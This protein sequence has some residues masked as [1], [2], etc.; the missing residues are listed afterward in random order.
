MVVK[1][2]ET[3]LDEA[4]GHLSVGRPHK[5]REAIVP[6]FTDFRHA[7]RDGSLPARIDERQRRASPGPVLCFHP[8]LRRGPRSRAEGR[9][10]QGVEQ[11]AAT[12]NHEMTVRGVEG[13]ED[14]CIWIEDKKETEQR[15]EPAK[16]I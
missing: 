5:G 1:I 12:S 16:F 15:F 8:Q 13:G 6:E 14:I 9:R 7:R 10:L 3:R 4:I 2:D 11:R